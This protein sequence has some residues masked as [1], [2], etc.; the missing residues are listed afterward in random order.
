MRI[1]MFGVALAALGAPGAVTARSL[2]GTAPFME[3]MSNHSL[4]EIS[5]CLAKAWEARSGETNYVPAET[6]F[7]MQLQ[8]DGQFTRLIAARVKVE[9]DKGQRKVLVYAPKNERKAKLRN[10]INGCV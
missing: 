9:E 4:G 6:G 3:L 10:E 8:Y 5:G 7:T 1:A 2:D